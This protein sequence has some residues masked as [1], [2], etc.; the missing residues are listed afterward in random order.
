MA[1]RPAVVERLAALRHEYR[2]KTVILGVDRLDYTKGLPP[3]LLALEELLRARPS[4]RDK[5][6]FIQVAAPSRTG[7]AEYQNLKREIDE[8]VG[9]V[10]GEFGSLESMPVVYINQ[11]VPRDQ[12]VALYQLADI[13]LVTPVR[14]GMNLVCLE[15]VAARGEAPGTLILSEFAGSATCM[16]GAVLINPHSPSQIAA[17]LAERLDDGKPSRSAFEHMREF[18]YSNTSIVWAERFLARLEAGFRQQHRLGSR[19]RLESETRRELIAAAK[20]PLVLLDYDGT[21]RAHTRFPSAAKPTS[22]VREIVGELAKTANVYV[23][24]G[25]PAETLEAWLGDLD[26][27]L[28]CEHG[29]AV[30]HRGGEWNEPQPTNNRILDEVVE[31]LFRDFAVRTPGSRVEVK[32]ASIAWHYRSSDPKL[33]AWRAKELRNL[34]ESQLIGSPF[35]VLSGSKVIEVR[36]VEITKGH[37][38]RALLQRFSDVDFV[39]CAGN[40]RTDEDMF[41]AIVQMASQPHVICYVGSV[42][43]Q[44]D[45]FVDTPEELLAQLQVLADWWR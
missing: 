18:V 9:R 10:N 38:A 43:S 19:L 1:E 8:L 28:V 45:Y 27:G 3:K 37:A 24:S 22:E 26:I 40:D 12:L 41:E 14:D 29:L 20:N 21:L 23:V 34:L 36:H 16:S 5:L 17:A 33:G 42:H 35:A 15:Y 11:S 32:K 31:P 30:R 39:F 25:R 2:D 13:M 6:V 44:A 7:V 4:L